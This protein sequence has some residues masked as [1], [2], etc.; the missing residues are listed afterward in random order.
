MTVVKGLT[1]G[2]A[3]EA[4]KTG[5]RVQR[6]GW[7][8]K[9]MWLALIKGATVQK[10]IGDCY[11][12]NGKTFPV[13]DAVYMKTADE[14]IVPWLCSQADMLANDWQT[15]VDEPKQQDDKIKVIRIYLDPSKSIGEQIQEAIKKITGERK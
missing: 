9:N 1:F 12:S 5:H 6:S 10:A 15:L 13:L 3:L 8:G 4:V 11:G 7:N 2:S 14:K